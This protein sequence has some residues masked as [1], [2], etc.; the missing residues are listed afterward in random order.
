[1]TWRRSA[2]AIVAFAMNAACIP[3]LDRGASAVVEPRIVAVRA[4]PAEARPGSTVSFTALVAAPGG[5]SPSIAWSFCETP[6]PL[7]TDDVVASACVTSPLP[8]AGA[9]TTVSLSTPTNACALFGPDAPGRLRPVDPDATGGYYQPVVVNLPDGV[10]TVMLARI[11]CDLPNASAAAAMAFAQSYVPNVNPTIES[12]TADVGGVPVDFDAVPGSALVHLHVAWP[13]GSVETYAYYD[14]AA[15]AVTWRR[16]AMSLAWYA[17][18]GTLDRESTVPGAGDPATVGGV[19]W[20][21]PAAAGAFRLWIVLRDDR[22]GVA[23]QVVDG[24]VVR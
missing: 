15:D 16:E 9:G 7:T 20:T 13:A 2:A 12:V 14:A 8:V 17:S 3:D 22:G 24:A 19:D 6:R 5:P 10:P 4:D 21:A 11:R 1:M 18:A 23:F